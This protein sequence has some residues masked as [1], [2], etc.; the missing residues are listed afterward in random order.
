MNPPLAF[1]GERIPRPTAGPP[2]KTRAATPTSLRTPP[3]F[4]HYNKPHQ[5]LKIKIYYRNHMI[6]LRK[7]PDPT[8]PTWLPKPGKQINFEKLDLPYAQRHSIIV[9]PPSEVGTTRIFMRTLESE[10]LLA[11]VKDLRRASGDS[12]DLEKLVGLLTASYNHLARSSVYSTPQ[13]TAALALIGIGT[14]AAY[15]RW[16]R[17]RLTLI[18]L[19][20]QESKQLQ[21]PKG[22]PAP[23]VLHLG[24]PVLPHTYYPAARIHNCLLEEELDELKLLLR[25]L[26]VASYQTRAYGEDSSGLSIGGW[27]KDQR[28][29]VEGDVSISRS[30]SGLWEDDYEEKARPPL[31]VG[32]IEDGLFYLSRR[33]RWRELLDER[34]RGQAPREKWVIREQ[35]LDG[36]IASFDASAGSLAKGGIRLGG[37]VKAGKSRS[38]SVEIEFSF[39]DSLTRG[40][41]SAEKGAET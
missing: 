7:T 41:S 33:S 13:I 26:G 36:A 9:L 20:P 21:F 25:R 35:Y 29:K 1:S 11:A 34:R 8:E 10:G 5:T 23:G 38:R 17:T 24:S 31:P 22:E 19:S 6:A 40:S 2:L 18:P 37:D 28:S 39:S 12:H 27:S 3:T 32:K 15:R 30:G 14:V 4:T 16:K